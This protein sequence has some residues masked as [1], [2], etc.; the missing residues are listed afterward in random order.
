MCQISILSQNRVRASKNE[1][2]ATW[3]SAAAICDIVQLGSDC[4]F[5]NPLQSQTK[6]TWRAMALQRFLGQAFGNCVFSE[7][8][9]ASPSRRA[10]LPPSIHSTSTPD[11]NIHTGSRD[12]HR[13]REI[14]GSASSRRACIQHPHRIARATNRWSTAVR[15]TPQASR[16]SRIS[17]TVKPSDRHT[18]RR[19]TTNH[20]WR[21]PSNHSWHKSSLTNNCKLTSM[22]SCRPRRWRRSNR[23]LRKS[24][25][26][27]ERLVALV[28]MR[29]AGVHGLGEIWRRHRLTC[30]SRQQLA[31]SVVR[32]TT[33]NA[34]TFSSIS[35]LGC[36]VC[37]ANLDDLKSQQSEKAP[38]RNCADDVTS[39]AVLGI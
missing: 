3:Y 36:R 6:T 38:E 31:A 2:L 29:E 9:Q 19:T 26:L 39:K 1:R 24:E 27:R 23:A 34:I 14:H 22:S 35:R 8:R 5:Y 25:Q 21:T 20:D 30:P 18:P 11:L 7:A 32:W 4:N 13:D 16:G 28:G 10:R 15:T 17:T 33:L 12:P 37:R